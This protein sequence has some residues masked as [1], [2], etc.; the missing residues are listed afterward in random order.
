MLRIENLTKTYGEKRAVDNLSLHIAPGEIYGFIGHNGAGKTTTLKAV[1]GILQFDKGEVFIKGESIR[2]NPL[3][4]KQKIAYIPDNPD[5]TPK[6]FL[7]LFQDLFQPLF[8][9]AELVCAFVAFD[10]R[11]Q[12]N[13]IRRHKQPPAGFSKIV[14]PADNNRNC[15]NK[16]NFSDNVQT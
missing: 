11:K 1:V 3:A 2:K 13:L 7:A 6:P 12:N 9:G 10:K 4:C 14:H 8:R 15:R 5:F 16:R